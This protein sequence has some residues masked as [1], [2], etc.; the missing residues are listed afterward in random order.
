MESLEKITTDSDLI[1]LWFLFSLITAYHINLT[2]TSTWLGEGEG[3]TV[4]K[5]NKYPFEYFFTWSN[6]LAHF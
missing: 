5:L 1:H 3:A 6:I 4:I 2:N